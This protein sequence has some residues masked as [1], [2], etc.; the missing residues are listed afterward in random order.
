M[1]VNVNVASTITVGAASPA[2]PTVGQ[3][4]TFPITY[5]QNAAGSPVARVIVDFGDG[6]V[7]QTIQGQPSGVTHVYNQAGTFSVRATAVDTFGDAAAGTPVSVT[8][9]NR[10][11]PTATISVAGSAA[12]TTGLVVTFSVTATEPSGSTATIQSVAIDFGDGSGVDLGGTTGT[13]IPV[14]HIFQSVGTYRV[15]LVV[16]DNAGASASAAT[17]VVVGA[18]QPLGVTV[19]ATRQSGTGAIIAI[20]EF[21]AVV[22]PATSGPTIGRYDWDFGDANAQ[23]TTSDTVTHSYTVWSGLKTITVTITAT[24]GQTATNATLVLP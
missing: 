11:Q 24:D 9:T 18:R 5:A 2:A 21:K 3:V 13:A 10:P 7:A 6:S 4:A 20:F 15:S 22:S 14:Q 16:R 17:L 1:T 12:P 19:S 8:V 23:T